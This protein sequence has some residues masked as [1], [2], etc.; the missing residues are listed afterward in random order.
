MAQDELALELRDGD[1]LALLRLARLEGQGQVALVRREHLHLDVGRGDR[2]H[3]VGHAVHDEAAVLGASQQRHA[4][5]Q[6]HV[7]R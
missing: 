7:L 6:V 2:H 3:G 4:H 1:L 5:P